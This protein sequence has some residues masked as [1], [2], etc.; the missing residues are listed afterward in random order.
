MI[1][2][3]Q[4]PLFASDGDYNLVMCYNEDRS[5]TIMVPMAFED[6]EIL[7]EDQDKVYVEAEPVGESFIVHRKLNPYFDW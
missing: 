6:M 2:K 4:R 7:F 5:R 3:M 1:F